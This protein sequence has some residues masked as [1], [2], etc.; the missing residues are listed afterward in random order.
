MRLIDADALPHS[1]QPGCNGSKWFVSDFRDYGADGLLLPV[2]PDCH[3]PLTWPLEN[4]DEPNMRDGA[5]WWCP[6][7]EELVEVVR[8]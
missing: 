3:S 1:W 6:V 4:E 8:P 7:C 2:C 5:Q